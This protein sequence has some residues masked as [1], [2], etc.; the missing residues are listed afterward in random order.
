[1][2]NQCQISFLIVSP[3]RYPLK[4]GKLPKPQFTQTFFFYNFAFPQFP[5]IF[6]HL[7]HPHSLY[8]FLCQ[9]NFD[10][11]KCIPLLVNF[12]CWKNVYNL[13]SKFWEYILNISFCWIFVMLTNAENVAQLR[14]LANQNCCGRLHPIGIF[15]KPAVFQSRDFCAKNVTFKCSNNMLLPQGGKESCIFISILKILLSSPSNR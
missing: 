3:K 5:H 4:G 8:N 14:F 2:Y 12:L 7:W 1:M 10:W 15:K 9:T 11:P 13:C 6:W